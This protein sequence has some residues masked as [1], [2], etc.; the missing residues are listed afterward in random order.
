MIPKATLISS[1]QWLND[2]VC[3]AM[4][5]LKAKDEAK[6]RLPPV[7]TYATPDEISDVVLQLLAGEAKAYSLKDLRVDARRSAYDRTWD[8]VISAISPLTGSR[9]MQG[10]TVTDHVIEDSVDSHQTLV[11]YLFKGF[12]K[13][14][15]EYGVAP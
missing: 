5:Q 7:V 15:D 3:T 10:V 8:I 14:A 4:E 9:E 12:A 6:K 1:P 11:A 13:L 2:I